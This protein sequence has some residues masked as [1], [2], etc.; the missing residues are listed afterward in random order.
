MFSRLIAALLCA[1]CSVAHAGG[2]YW[3][4][5]GANQLK[6]MNFAGSNLQTVTLTGAVTTPGTNIR[7][8]AF[9]GVGRRLFWADNGLDRLLRANVD[10]SASKILYTVPGG[11]SFPADVRLDL[12]NQFF[13][14]C[15]QLL[16]R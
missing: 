8:I 15:D 10:G 1:V 14:W 2:I 13:Y 11:T 16:N 3:S 7:G 9:D 12:G 4:D 5:R 6:R